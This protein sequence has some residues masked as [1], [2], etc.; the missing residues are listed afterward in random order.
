MYVLHNYVAMHRREMGINNDDTHALFCWNRL[1]L[2]CVQALKIFILF[3]SQIIIAVPGSP[4]IP[5]HI[6][7]SISECPSP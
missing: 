7:Q 3:K 2:K 1:D 6:A 4:S 5:P